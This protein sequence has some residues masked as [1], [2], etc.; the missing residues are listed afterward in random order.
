MRIQEEEERDMERDTDGERARTGKRRPRIQYA[1]GRSGK[2][3]DER[4]V[5]NGDVDDNGDRSVGLE[6][7]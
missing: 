2:N 6:G 3:C 1:D 4:V 7:V 5:V